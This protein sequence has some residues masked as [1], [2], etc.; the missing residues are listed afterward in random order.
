M[1]NLTDIVITEGQFYLILAGFVFWSVAIF[2]LGVAIARV[3]RRKDEEI[4]SWIKV[5]HLQNPEP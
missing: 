1:K 4:N 5:S 2:L 3:E